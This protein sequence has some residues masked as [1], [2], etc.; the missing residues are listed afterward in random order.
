MRDSFFFNNKI[1]YKVNFKCDTK[2]T[3]YIEIVQ[4][5]D[6]HD[7]VKFKESDD[8]FL[9]TYDVGY[10]DITE[11]HFLEHGNIESNLLTDVEC[12]KKQKILRELILEM[13]Y[14]FRNDPH[15]VA[16]IYHNGEMVEYRSR[17]NGNGTM[18]QLRD[19]PAEV[20]YE[21]TKKFVLDEKY[22][23]MESY[24]S[25]Y[26]PFETILFKQEDVEVVT[27]LESVSKSK[28]ILELDETVDVDTLGKYFY[29]NKRYILY[30]VCD[31]SKLD[32][33]RQCTLLALCKRGEIPIVTSIYRAHQFQYGNVYPYD[34]NYKPLPGPVS[35][36]TSGCL[37]P[38]I[39]TNC[40]RE[41]VRVDQRYPQF[42]YH[43][44][45]LC[46]DIHTKVIVIDHV[47]YSYG[48][49][50]SKNQKDDFTEIARMISSNLIKK[51]VIFRTN[52]PKIAEMMHVSGAIVV[53]NNKRLREMVD[54]FMN[55]MTKY[56]IFE[57]NKGDT[58]ENMK[59]VTEDEKFLEEFHKNLKL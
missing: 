55:A 38:N 14:L 47:F 18:V 32:K 56:K 8:G 34:E 19:G 49:Y 26:K 41:Y 48:Q 16:I 44:M 43:V 27:D 5:D 58:E 13:F 6:C 21:K 39:P 29:V 51:P 59:Q 11:E 30:V 33:V 2:E 40:I 9:C 12:P 15:T 54:T 20:P 37:F 53:S 31:T 46:S 3:A 28:H 50:S 52:F 23:N 57:Y 25:T 7:V 24:S 10:R 42:K 45:K 35:V 36:I 4:S 22:H 17:P 1:M